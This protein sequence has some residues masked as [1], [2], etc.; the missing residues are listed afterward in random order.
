MW[1]GWRSGTWY[2]VTRGLGIVII[3][4]LLAGC[5]RWQLPVRS[6]RLAVTLSQMLDLAIL[7]AARMVMLRVGLW[8]CGIA[9]AIGLLGTWIRVRASGLPRMSPIVGLILLTRLIRTGAVFVRPPV[10]R[11]SDATSC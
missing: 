1:I 9:A 6:A 3:S 7:R 2:F 11:T 5:A 4:I 10:P 8:S